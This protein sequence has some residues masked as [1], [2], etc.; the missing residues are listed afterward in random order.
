MC[1]R[2]MLLG[3]CVPGAIFP[4]DVMSLVLFIKNLSCKYDTPCVLE[5]EYVKLQAAEQCPSLSLKKG[6]GE[7]GG[8]GRRATVPLAGGFNEC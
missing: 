6:V 5:V 4:L 7:G 3:Y 8:G 1:P 2:T